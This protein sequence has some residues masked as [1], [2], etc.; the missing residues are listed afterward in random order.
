MEVVVK[1][2]N[3]I[4][5]KSL[6]RREFRQFLEDIGQHY[7]ELLL[8]CE[9]RWLS[10]GMVL[11][12]FWSLKDSVHQFLTE[13]NELSE[14]RKYLLD[15]EWL[16]DLDFLVDITSHLNDLNVKL[17]G[18]SKLFTNM[19]NDVNSFE[20]KLGLFVGQIAQKK[21]DNF[22][23]LKQRQVLNVLDTDRYAR[24]IEVLQEA[25]RSRFGGLECERRSVLLFTNPFVF[26][27]TNIDSLPDE[28]QLEVIDLQNDSYLKGRFME[29]PSIPS[30]CEMISFW[31]M[32]PVTEYQNL[33]LFAQ[34][35]IS[36]FG[37]TYR[38]EQAFSAMKLIK[39][40]NRALLT[41]QHLNSLMTVAVTELKPD[42]DKLVKSVQKQVS[43]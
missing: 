42:I 30:S 27:E 40:R 13:I 12:R 8:H 19:C 24:K 1:C 15:D 2:V 14:E 39:S 29:L 26:P 35:Y 22:P 38:C 21:L 31:Q 20:K 43:H 7:G 28:I 4:R 36:R 33:R 34:R 10:K 32:L 23:H 9:V 41:D 5:A 16:N 17:Q 11:S 25:F 18:G 3:K 6:N 37:S